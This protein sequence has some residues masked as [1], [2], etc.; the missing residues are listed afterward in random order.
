[1]GTPSAAYGQTAAYTIRVSRTHSSSLATRA[2]P[3]LNDIERPLGFTNMLNNFSKD[4]KKNPY[5]VDI[6]PYSGAGSLSK[7]S[8]GYV[9]TGLNM[10]VKNGASLDNGRVYFTTDPKW[11]NSGLRRRLTVT[12]VR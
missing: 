2:Q 5:A 11:S 1:M 4:E 12:L 8:G 10:G 7:Y 6:M 9:M 3:L